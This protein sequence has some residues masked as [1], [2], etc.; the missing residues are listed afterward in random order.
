[1]FVT[2]SILYLYLTQHD[3]LDPYIELVGKVERDCSLSI[4]RVVNFG[5]D[6]G[7]N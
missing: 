5:V 3:A 6:F 1:M 2:V 7:K 4:E